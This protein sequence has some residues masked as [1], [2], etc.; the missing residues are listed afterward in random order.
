MNTLIQ[1]APVIT[2]VILG[3]LLKQVGLVHSDD[4]HALLRV[5]VNCTLPALIFKSL[6][7][8]E[9][10]GGQFAVLALCGAV[11][12]IVLHMVAGS[13]SLIMGLPPK[14]AG[15]VVVST[16]ASNVGMFL[17]G[18]FLVQYGTN[19]VGRVAAFDLG[20]S[21]IASSYAYYVA[22]RYAGGTDWRWQSGVK[23]VLALPMFWANILGIVVN[24]AGI[25]LPDILNK[26]LESLTLGNLALSML[27]LGLFI[28]LRVT[29]WKAVLTAVGL[30]MLLGAAIGQ[31]LV[32]I[33]GLSGV[34]RAAVAIGAAAPVGIMPLIYAIQEG[35]DVDVAA[36]ALSL[37]LVIGILTTPL[38]L[39]VYR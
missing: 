1:F 11:I 35:L 15:S 37:S 18:F 10:G 21:L 13:M 3:F 23:K 16:L 2:P 12:P 32:L 8:C 6:A 36:S 30:R 7:T 34:E 20:N 14:V 27:A 38:L 5:V 28:E 19:G 22:T 4:G 25:V 26:S 33:I 9:M 29:H 39:G 24:L 17:P 31:A